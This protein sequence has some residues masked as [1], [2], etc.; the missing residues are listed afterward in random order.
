M[1]PAHRGEASIKRLGKSYTTG[2]LVHTPGPCELA[3]SG[4]DLLLE[5][6]TERPHAKRFR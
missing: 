4:G 5:N 6:P 2:I 1:V 3:E